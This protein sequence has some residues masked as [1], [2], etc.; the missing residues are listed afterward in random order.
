MNASKSPANKNGSVDCERID[1]SQNCILRQINNLSVL[2]A[3]SLAAEGGARRR[4]EPGRGRRAFVCL[5]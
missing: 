3:C 4:R 1:T 5:L 2:S